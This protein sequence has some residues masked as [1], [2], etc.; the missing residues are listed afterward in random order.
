MWTAQGA[1]QPA[2]STWLVERRGNV[3]RLKTRPAALQ[4]I[5]LLLDALRE[6]DALEQP[7]LADIAE[8]A[9][10]CG[11]STY[12]LCFTPFEDMLEGLPTSAGSFADTATDPLS[13]GTL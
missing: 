10:D 13:V 4:E 9:Y 1:L 12:Q 3:Y 2:L 6:L 5:E 8:A 7:A 11:R